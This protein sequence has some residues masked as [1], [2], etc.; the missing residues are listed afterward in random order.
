MHVRV[1]MIRVLYDNIR[2]DDAEVKFQN[3][4]IIILFYIYIIVMVVACECNNII[5]MRNN[6]LCL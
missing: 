1:I 6:I 5:I 4:F 2:A 3:A